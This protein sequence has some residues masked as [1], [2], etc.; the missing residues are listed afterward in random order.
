VTKGELVIYYKKVAPKMIALIKNRPLMMQRFPNGIKHESFF[1]KNAGEYFPKWIKT[2]SVKKEGGSVNMV[3]CND[4]KTLAYLANQACITLH[5]WPSQIDKLNYPD[6]MIFDLDPSGANFSLVVQ[7]A[8]DLRC[9]LEQQLNLKTF[10]MTTGSKGL[11]IVVPIKREWT[12][13]KVRSFAKNVAKVLVK[14]DPKKYTLEHR[15]NKRRGRLFID[16]LRNGYAQTSVAPF[17]IRPYEQ[18]PVAAPLSW[19]ELGP[20]LNPKSYTLK[21]IHTKLK[22]N[23]WKNINGCSKSLKKAEKKLN[24]LLEAFSE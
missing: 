8:K 10:V 16:Y 24:Q 11:H 3:V 15:K 4:S 21:N 18:A 9:I 6:R 20:K 17:S 7:G 12:F 14:Q 22:S 23:P 5:I 19:K 1:Q 2:K 13:E